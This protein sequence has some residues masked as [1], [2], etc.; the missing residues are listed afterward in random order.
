M[1]ILELYNSIPD[2]TDER[3]FWMDDRMFSIVPRGTCFTIRL[4]Y[5]QPMSMS[6][7]YKIF[8]RVVNCYAFTSDKSVEHAAEVMGFKPVKII[9][10]IADWLNA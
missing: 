6:D 5:T 2:T 4:W 1:T 8:P 3:E 7:A 9:K 10:N